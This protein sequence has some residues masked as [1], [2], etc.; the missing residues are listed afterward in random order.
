MLNH[1]EHPTDP[2]SGRGITVILG[3]DSSAGCGIG[4]CPFRGTMY[5]QR[6]NNQDEF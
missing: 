3:A 1:S 5:A 6:E 4:P 2:G